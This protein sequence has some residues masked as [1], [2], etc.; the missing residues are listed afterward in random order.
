M[1]ITELDRSWKGKKLLFRYTTSFFHDIVIREEED[2]TSFQVTRKPYN[3]PVEHQFES[4]LLSDWLT[5]PRLFAA[6]EGDD[7]MGV[8][9]L[10]AEDW[11][12]R[13]R[14]ANL[15]VAEGHRFNGIGKKL[16]GRGIQAARESGKRAVVLEV[17]SC[18]DPAIRFYRSCGFSIIGLDTIHYTN[19]DIERREARLEMGLL[20]EE[21]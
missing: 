16:M 12:N 10:S 4:G 1:I 20:L 14:V 6:M 17:Q 7:L 21:T 19:H 2:S 13:L 9:E 3:Q 5:E 18:N 15:W 11:N 8:I